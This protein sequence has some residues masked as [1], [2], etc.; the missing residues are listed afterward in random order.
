MAELPFWGE[1][2]HKTMLVTGATGLL[3]SYVTLAAVAANRIGDYGI[4]IYALGRNTEKFA[5][6][7]PSK[8][9][10]FV[11]Q[12]IQNP[13]TIDEDIHYLVHTAG[14]VGPSIFRDTPLDVIST[15]VEGTLSLIDHVKQRNCKGFV[16]ASTHEIYGAAEGEKY[17]S[18]FPVGVDLSNPRS[19]YILAKQACE[20]ALVC[21]TV[22]Y[23]MRTMSLRLSRLYGP[24]MNLDSG[25]FVCDFIQDLLHKRPVR[26]RGDLNLIRPLCYV[27]DAAAAALFVL[28]DGLSG[29]AYNVQNEEIPTI[30]EIAGLLSGSIIADN[31]DTK[32]LPPTGHWLNVNKLKAIGWR[33]S[34]PLA[35]GLHRTVEYFSTLRT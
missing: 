15:N 21:A 14:P 24:L 5:S 25:L 13:L 17:E 32:T 8:E 1:M 3:G 34:M 33:Q 23:P 9:C 31:P 12:D 29:E 2:A 26:I 28:A 16:F 10:I 30:H 20:N 27:A 22:Q 6:L 19:C 4:K 11:L 7:Y 18:D 35:D